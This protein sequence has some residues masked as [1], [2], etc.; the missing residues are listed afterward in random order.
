MET[1]KMSK[2]CGFPDCKEPLK[3]IA[4]A[5][6]EDEGHL[7]AVILRSFLELREAKKNCTHGRVKTRFKAPKGKYLV[8]GVDTFEGPTADYEIGTYKSKEEALSVANSRGGEMNKTY[9]YDD[10]GYEVSG[11]YGSF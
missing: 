6:D 8:I 10:E 1:T 11:G 7:R 5:D 9:V 4:F 2:Y 3:S